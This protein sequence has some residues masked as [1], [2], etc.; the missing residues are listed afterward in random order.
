MAGNRF[1][2][3]LQAIKSRMMFE[4]TPVDPS[5]R[6][7]FTLPPEQT[8]L[9]E[10]VDPYG[11]TKS[12]LTQL[13]QKPVDRREFL[14][15]TG[16]SASSTA[17]RG[18]L[19]ELAK[20][21]ETGAEK[22]LPV[23]K[24]VVKLP[25]VNSRMLSKMNRAIDN[26]MDYFGESSFGYDLESYLP[27]LNKIKKSYLPLLPPEVL[28]TVKGRVKD[29]KTYLKVIND[30]AKLEELQRKLAEKHGYADDA[31]IMYETE[32]GLFENLR[33]MAR[34]LPEE[35][36]ANLLNDV[37]AINEGAYVRGKRYAD[38]DE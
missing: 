23:A 26:A 5:R 12:P 14:K 35:E 7:L 9:P 6:K 17:M 30:E 28:D 32:E 11:Q 24:E 29:A 33:D 16:R 25:K 15:Q 4:D 1:T 22:A 34:Y 10:A 31:D 13:S 3:K 38:E 2:K 21:A 37:K 36:A 19:P 27:M 8:M 18:I 20:L